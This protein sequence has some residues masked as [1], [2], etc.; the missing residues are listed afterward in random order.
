MK[1]FTVLITMC[2]VFGFTTNNSKLLYKSVE[3]KVQFK[4]DAPLEIIEAKST[5]L[6][7]IIDVDKRTFAFT[8]PIRS[9][10]GFNSPLQKEHFNE[11]Y[12]ESTK[13][14]NATFAGKII[15][16][17]DFLNDGTYTIRAKG[18]LTIHGVEQ[19]RILKSKIV[20][21]GDRFTLLS[22]FT[23]I[24]EEYDISVPKIVYQK[25]A[26]EIHVQVEASFEKN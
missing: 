11:N 4:S 25:I 6:R 16:K 22:Y 13:Y 17:I 1:T 12:L 23:I 26:E 15:E 2:L 20:V 19:E 5:S 8:I 7:G 14:P 3:G 10:E 24:L 21:K 9:F 18:K